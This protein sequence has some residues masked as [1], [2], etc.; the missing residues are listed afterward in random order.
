MLRYLAVQV[1]ELPDAETGIS[2]F[3]RIPDKALGLPR[4][5]LLLISYTKNKKKESFFENRI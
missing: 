2:F 4:T 1:L 5:N 3:G